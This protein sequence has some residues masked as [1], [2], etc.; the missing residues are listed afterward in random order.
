MSRRTRI[1]VVVAALL[2]IAY[3]TAPLLVRRHV[4]GLIQ[5]SVGRPLPDFTLV[6][7]GGT[8]WT[9][10]GLRGKRVV[11]HFFRSRC[12]SCDLEA[13]AIRDL[14]AN[15]P[16]DVVLLHVMNDVVQGFPSVETEATIAAKGFT[17]PIALADRAF[18]DAFH[19]ASW[20]NVTPVTYVVDAQGI[21]RYGLRG[22][23][24]R[25][26]IEQA[27]DAVR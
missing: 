10:A 27:I 17:R 25:A 1:A 3:W 19:G 2:G 9:T 12:H 22:A 5:H 13:A 8:S 16:G 14:E 26:S 11:L 7:R 21:V 6:D 4:D 24:T 20:S 23:Q 15:L 18:A